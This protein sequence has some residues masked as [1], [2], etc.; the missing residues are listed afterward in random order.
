LFAFRFEDYKH[1]GSNESVCNL[2]AQADWHPPRVVA[3][4]ICPSRAATRTKHSYPF[5]YPPR[6]MATNVAARKTRIP[7]VELIQ[8]IHFSVFSLFFTC[9]IVSSA[10]PQRAIEK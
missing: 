4:Q 6:V 2:V 9:S 8:S 7:T 5:L 10:S 3:H 1:K